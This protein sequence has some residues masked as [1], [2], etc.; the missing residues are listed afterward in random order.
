MISVDYSCNRRGCT[1]RLP[2]E[3]CGCPE[4]AGHY[5]RD[6]ALESEM[7]CPCGGELQQDEYFKVCC[8][9]KLPAEVVQCKTLKERLTALNEIRPRYNFIE[10][11]FENYR[12]IIVNC[13]RQARA[14]GSEAPDNEGYYL[15]TR[16]PLEYFTAIEASEI[17]IAHAVPSNVKQLLSLLSDQYFMD[18]ILEQIDSAPRTNE[19][20]DELKSSWKM[21]SLIVGTWI[22]HDGEAKC[23][24]SYRDSIEL[25]RKHLNRE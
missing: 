25:L 7:I 1:N 9:K 16:M 18:E 24:Q 11:E 10:A 8:P 12:S 13:E 4:C 3:Y 23:F 21:Y 17:L 14:N 5:C 20:W 15:L 19:E 22:P 2:E 6:C